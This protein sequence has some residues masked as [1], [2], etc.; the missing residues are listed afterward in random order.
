ME[1]RSILIT[2]TSSDYEL[3]D[4]GDGE[5]L[6]RLGKVILARPD[7]Q[8]LWLKHL[9]KKRW[10]DANVIFKPGEGG[11]SGS[12]KVSMGVPKSWQITFTE[13]GLVFKI[14]LAPFK[15]IG[16]FPEQYANWQWII[17]KIKATDRPTSVLNLFGYTGGATLAALSAGAQVVHVDGSKTAIALA[18]ENAT[19][20][21]LSDK[22]VRWIIDDAKKF[23]DREIR[24]GNKYDAIIMDPPAFGHGAKGELW[25]IEE[26]LTPLIETAMKLL[27]DKPL[28]FILNGYSAGYSSIAYENNLKP[29]VQKFNG[30]LESGELTLRE[31]SEGG[32]LLPCG[33]FARWSAF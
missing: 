22:P 33:I 13:L 20:S 30:V 1:H 7:P 10:Q 3:L 17:D 28:F 32:R 15:H 6:E 8:A 5:K 16:L 11:K 14:V 19:L 24:R 29:L 18:K 27:S 23:V 21:K 26:D 2:E 31:S 9:D 12:W 25:K 4:S